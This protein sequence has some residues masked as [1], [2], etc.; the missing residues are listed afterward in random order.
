MLPRSP[1]YR[2]RTQR[3][4]LPSLDRMDWRVDVAITTTHL[5]RAFK[6][7]VTF[8]VTTTDGRIHTFE[9]SVDKF[10]QVRFLPPPS[11]ECLCSCS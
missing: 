6:P 9:S 2:A 8:Q 7:T 5:V 4:V 1:L 11:D 10:H 3:I